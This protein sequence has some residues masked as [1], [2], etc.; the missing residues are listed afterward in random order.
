MDISNAI[1][2][3]LNYCI[4]EKGLSDKS[5]ISYENDLSVY[6]EFL[7]KRNFTYVFYIIS[8]DIKVFL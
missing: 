4:F 7:N 3:F 5:K 2:D 8:E 1:Q 6:K